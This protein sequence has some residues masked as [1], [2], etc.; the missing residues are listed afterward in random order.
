MVAGVGTILCVALFLSPE[1]QG[2]YYT[3]FS[4]IA[5]Q[6]I[7]ELGINI[8]VVQF[9]SH[10]YSRLRWDG[11]I[12]TGDPSALARLRSLLGFLIAWFTVAAVV[13]VIVA[14]PLGL[15]ILSPNGI[16]PGDFD[17]RNP[18]IILTFLCAIA[19]PVSAALSLA[20]GLG[21]LVSVSQVRL[22][23][24]IASAISTWSSLWTGF[25]LYAICIGYGIGLI[26]AITWITRRLS[27][28]LILLLHTTGSSDLNWAKD[29]WPFQWRIAVSSISGYVVYQLPNPLLM[30]WHGPAAA[31]QFGMSMQ[32]F[33]AINNGALAWIST[34]VPL[35]G[36]LVAQCRKAELNRI[37]RLR[38]AQS[39]F[40]LV[41]ALFVLAV[42]YWALAPLGF[43]YLKQRLVSPALLSIFALLC[44]ANHL[45]FAQLAYLRAH[46]KENFVGGAVLSALSS[47]ALLILLVPGYSTVGVVV[48]S[49]VS[50]IAISLASSSYLFRKSYVSK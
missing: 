18:W 37:F 44:A 30:V 47:A 4:L 27:A 14:L 13:F 9:A 46:K 16:D 6:I 7:A 41:I 19:L 49:G 28:C 50:T 25:H 5:L 31:G 3:F 1:G 8:T 15:L 11:A 36:Q 32:I 10:E 22:M 23:Q 24:A 40:V 42:L 2:Y 17:V 29:L 26:V 45:I 39:T 38:F 35:F 34:S 21:L 33:T 20:E 43:A 12:L 48:A